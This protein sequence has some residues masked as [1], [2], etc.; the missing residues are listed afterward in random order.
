MSMMGNVFKRNLI[1]TAVVLASPAIHAGAYIFASEENGIDLI[2]HPNTYTGVE[3]VVN[4]RICINPASP[5]AAQMEIPVQNNINIFNQLQSTSGNIKSGTNNNIGGSQLDFESVALHEIGHCLG[6]AHANLASESG[7][8]DNRQNYT[9]STDGAD[10]S[11][12]VAA[13]V[14][15]VIGSSDDVRGDD[16][17]LHWFRKSNNNPFT[18]DSVIDETTYSIDAAD[19]PDGDLFAANANRDLSTLLGMVKTEAVMQQGTYFDE[20]Q[21]TLGHDDV[22]TISYGAS[23]LDEESGTGDDYTVQ[24]EYGGI[25]DTGCDVSLSV[26]DTAGLAF[27]SVGGTFIGTTLPPPRRVFNHLRVTSAFIEFGEGFNWFFNQETV[28]QAPVLTAIGNQTMDEQDVLPINIT[29]S[30]L[31]GDVLTIAASGLP[32]FAGLVDNGDGTATLTVSP[33]LGDASTTMVT[34]TVTDD[35]LPNVSTQETFQLTVNALDT[36]G[37]GLS[38]YDEINTYGT[39]PNNPDTDGDLINDGDEVAAGSNPSD[40]LS[41][42]NYADGDIAPLG[43]PDGQVNAA[44]Y[45]V[46]QR[47]VLGEILPSPLELAH[48]DLYPV[49]MPDGV[50][51]VSDLILLLGIVQ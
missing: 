28:N 24:L 25:S 29:A 35:G 40:P 3:P 26:T 46:A 38:D 5:N 36:D 50:I 2:V 15:G 19:L 49:G 13:G 9:R 10:N 21:R 32:I 11:F 18:I 20:A 33:L 8:T 48:G 4:V 6:M 34:I 12:N 30:D 47:I 44:D 1:L 39:L 43:T 45:L 14:D 16:V 51:D 37:D 17:N 42:P 31:E 27:C 23:G 41:W 7:F 22:A